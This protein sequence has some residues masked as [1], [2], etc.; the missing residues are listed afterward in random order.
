M[1]QLYIK[2]YVAFLIITML[3][4]FISG[5]I[6]TALFGRPASEIAIASEIGVAAASLPSSQDPAFP[7]A[8]RRLVEDVQAPEVRVMDAHVVG[9]RGIEHLRRGLR[10]PDG[11]DELANQFVSRKF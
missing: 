5:S 8:F 10:R 4:L 2:I 7:K 6:A 11:R 3:A 1:R 9:D